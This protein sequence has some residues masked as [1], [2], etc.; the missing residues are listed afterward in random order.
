MGGVLASFIRLYDYQ[1]VEIHGS[2]QV[3]WDNMVLV[4]SFA[5]TLLIFAKGSFGTKFE[6]FN[7]AVSIGMFLFL[8]VDKITKVYGSHLPHCK[9]KTQT[10]N[11]LQFSLFS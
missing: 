1:T 2:S 3:A 6:K 7:F 5:I 8:I 4:W 9:Q 11:L 10:Q